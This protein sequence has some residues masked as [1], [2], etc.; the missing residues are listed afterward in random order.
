MIA[1]WEPLG[2]CEMIWWGHRM[3]DGKTWVEYH[4]PDDHRSH[5]HLGFTI[6]FADSLASYDSLVEWTVHW[7]YPELRAA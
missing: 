3:T 2:L 6:A 5:L 7:A 4:G 1:A